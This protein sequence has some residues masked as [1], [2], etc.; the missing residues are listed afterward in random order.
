V[1]DWRLHWKFLKI[2]KI[3][4]FTY[5]FFIVICPILTVTGTAALII[6]TGTSALVTVTKIATVVT[7]TGTVVFVFPCQRFVLVKQIDEL[8]IK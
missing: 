7:V 1:V 3:S 6:V 5:L 2:R 4:G 8:V